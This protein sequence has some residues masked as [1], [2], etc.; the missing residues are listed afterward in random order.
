MA[1]R[2]RPRTKVLRAVWVGV[3]INVRVVWV[4]ARG[5]AY[6]SAFKAYIV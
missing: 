2:Y 5:S 1:G 3:R 4:D 6:A